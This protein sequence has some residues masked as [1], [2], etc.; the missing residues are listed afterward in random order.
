M[1]RLGKFE[2]IM[3]MVNCIIDAKFSTGANFYV[4]GGQY[5]H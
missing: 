3:P 1:G 4:N 5:M 2:D